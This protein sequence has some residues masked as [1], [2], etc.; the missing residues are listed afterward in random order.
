MKCSHCLFLLYILKQYSQYH[1]C[2][3]YPVLFECQWY[4]QIP[5]FIPFHVS[6]FLDVDNVILISHQG[7]QDCLSYHSQVSSLIWCGLK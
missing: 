3:S 1:I 7:L 6:A 4:L 2:I 5:I